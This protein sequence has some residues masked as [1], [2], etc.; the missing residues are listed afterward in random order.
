MKG[1]LA[2][3]PE[4]VNESDEELSRTALHWAA[5]EGHR[6]VVEALLASGA[7]VEARDKDGR[8]PLTIAASCNRKHISDGCCGCSSDNGTKNGILA[9]KHCR[10]HS[11]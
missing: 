10:F 6:E 9:A 8:S 4:S 3:N 11:L 2:K 7:N 1:L 5:A